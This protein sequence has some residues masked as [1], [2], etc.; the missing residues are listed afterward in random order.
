MVDA[1]ESWALDPDRRSGDVGIVQTQYGYHI[2]YFVGDT[3]TPIWKVSA[4]SAISNED[5]NSAA[6]ELDNAYSIK[7]NWFG[8]FYIEKDTDIDA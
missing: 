8:R 1:F 4:Q 5:A 2:M 6:E 3:D 7:M